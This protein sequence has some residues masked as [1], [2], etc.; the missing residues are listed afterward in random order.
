METWR[1]DL[2]Q[3]PSSQF[4][5]NA[6]LRGALSGQISG[7]RIVTSYINTCIQLTVKI[8]PLNIY[9]RQNK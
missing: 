7:I 6:R 5:P 3:C 9:V 2:A 4:D 1:L 8:S